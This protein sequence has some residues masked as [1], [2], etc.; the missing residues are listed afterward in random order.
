[1]MDPQA[2]IK[3]YTAFLQ[4]LRYPLM[5]QNIMNE[6]SMHAYTENCSIV[7]LTYPLML[8][9][10]IFGGPYIFAH[11]LQFLITCS[12]HKQIELRSKLPSVLFLAQTRMIEELYTPFFTNTAFGQMLE[13]H[14]HR[15]GMRLQL[16]C[17]K[18]RLLS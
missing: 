7:V 17:K 12:I 11:Q 18:K 3:N 2:K 10:S 6:R 5:L 8:Q 1:M 13:V 15:L 16:H 14:G 9:S 4:M